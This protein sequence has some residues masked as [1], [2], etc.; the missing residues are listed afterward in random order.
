MSDNQSIRVVVIGGGTGTFTVLSAL[1]PHP[2]IHLTAIVNMVDDGGSTGVLR[3]ELGVLPPGD[4]RQC[5]VALCSDSQLMR[6][7]LNYRFNNGSLGGHALGNLLLTALEKL[8][9]SFAE[10][11]KAAGILFKIEGDVVPVTTDDVR[12]CLQRADGQIVVGEKL[13]LSSFF[14]A[15]EKPRLFLQPEA[16]INPE[17]KTAIRL[18]DVIIVGPGNLYT[19][20]VPTL[21]VGGVAEALRGARAKKIY[22]CNLVTKPGQTHDFQVHDFLD[23]IERYAGVGLFDFVLYNNRKPDR[24]LLEIYEQHDEQWVGFDQQLLEN[25]SYRAV[26]ADFLSHEPIKPN[27]NDHLIKR[28]LIRHDGQKLAKAIMA[29]LK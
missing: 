10:A 28:N 25:Q 16:T 3:D 12:L 29:I 8:T 18:A 7:L 6:D 17:A 19:T 2:S 23:E 15:N 11:V 24:E 1:K 26:G 20:L 5:L 27:P 21:L 22:I 14:R 13:I 9:G 4:V